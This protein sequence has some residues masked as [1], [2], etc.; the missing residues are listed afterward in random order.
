MFP[1]IFEQLTENVSCFFVLI[2][3]GVNICNLNNCLHFIECIEVLIDFL[4]VKIGNS[5]M[6]C[7]QEQCKLFLGRIPL[8]KRPQY[9][10]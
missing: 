10:F 9:S 8:I 5:K 3:I 2:K 6:D 4:Q 1:H 7:L